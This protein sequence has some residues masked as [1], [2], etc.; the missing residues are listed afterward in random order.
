MSNNWD[1]PDGN[2]KF[3]CLIFALVG[4]VVLVV[5]F[6]ALNAMFATFVNGLSKI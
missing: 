3:S 5:G 6:I 2:G 1:G 4:L